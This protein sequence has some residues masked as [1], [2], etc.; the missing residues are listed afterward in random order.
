MRRVIDLENMNCCQKVL[1]WLVYSKERRHLLKV[2]R[3]IQTFNHTTLKE[4]LQEPNFDVNQ[5]FL[6][7]ENYENNHRSLFYIFYNS[8]DFLSL[9]KDGVPE[10]DDILKTLDV[11]LAAGFDVNKPHCDVFGPFRRPTLAFFSFFQ[12]TVFAITKL[13][14]MRRCIENSNDVNFH[15]KYGMCSNL[16][17]VVSWYN[18]IC[19]NPHDHLSLLLPYLLEIMEELLIRGHVITSSEIEKYKRNAVLTC[20]FEKEWPMLMTIYCMQKKDIN[21]FYE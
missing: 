3:A 2:I 20:F 15:L 13:K 4:I 21:V 18:K 14:I 19:L 8:I 1:F 10:D 11:L 7:R 9:Y 16:L 12:Y 6:I 5:E 17:A